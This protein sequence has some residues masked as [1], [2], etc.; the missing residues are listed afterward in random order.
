MHQ[1]REC[2][3]HVPATHQLIQPLRMLRPRQAEPLP[4]RFITVRLV[5]VLRFLEGEDRLIFLRHAVSVHPTTDIHLWC[6][7][8]GVTMLRGMAYPLSNMSVGDV[9][10][11]DRPLGTLQI[12]KTRANEWEARA[13]RN[14]ERVVIAS[15]NG[16]GGFFQIQKLIGKRDTVGRGTESG[17]FA[18]LDELLGTP[19]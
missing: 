2:L 14:D 12:E 18:I 5:H 19:L 3:E 15:I 9:E 6:A 17:V 11:F 16:V 8:I 10:D 1:Y 7:M 13:W 4:H